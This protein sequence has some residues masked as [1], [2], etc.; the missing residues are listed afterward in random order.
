MSDEFLSFIPSYLPFF[1]I[2]LAV[3]LAVIEALSMGLTTIWFVI[4][5]LVSAVTALLGGNP[6]VQIVIF[7][8][9][10]IVILY[11]TR[12]IAL[13][14]LRV[15][16]EKSNLDQMAGKIG[17]VTEAIIPFESGQVKVGGQI[18]TAAAFRIEDKISAGS[19]VRVIKIEGV[20]LIVEPVSGK[21][22]ENAV[23]DQQN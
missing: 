4:G 6:I 21:E 3:F 19:E 1:W 5:A 11:F 7:L 17:L 22:P 9:V 18:W 13:R 8:A 23:S 16:S 2:I 10:S 14:K 15:G 20:K 12:P